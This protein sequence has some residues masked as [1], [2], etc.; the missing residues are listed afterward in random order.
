MLV[1]RAWLVRAAEAQH[2]NN[3]DDRCWMAPAAIVL[4]AQFLF[5]AS[6]ALLFE[7]HQPPPFAKYAKVAIG[8]VLLVLGCRAAWNLRDKPE[9]PTKHLLSLD[10]SRYRGF[11]FAMVFLWLQFVALTWGKAMLPIAT[12]MWADPALAS[13]DAA[14]F[15]NDAWR[16]IPPATRFVDVVY[17]IW[18]PTVGAAF[19][20]LYFSRRTNRSAALLA[21][22]LTIGLLG[23]VGQYLF[24]SGG[25]IFFERMGLGDRFADLPTGFAT[26]RAADVLWNAYQGNYMSFATGISAFPSIHVAVVTWMALAFRNPLVT[27]YAVVIF[28]GSIMLGWHYGIDGIAGA[29]GAVACYL[30]AGALL[31][32][33]SARKELELAVGNASVRLP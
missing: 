16:V 20:T 30:A 17:M 12:S 28:L 15:G 24:P 26:N 9:V 3:I 2:G 22:F 7:F 14:I 29:T 10:W 23:T 21:L 11:V 27:V 4:A 32:L 1:R 8:F 6:V 33:T 13:A 31:K 5:C 18:L 19:A 25:P